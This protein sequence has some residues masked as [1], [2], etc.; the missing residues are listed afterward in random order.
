LEIV[1][2]RLAP[3]RWARAVPGL[4]RFYAQRMMAR[5]D[6]TG[7]H[8]GIYGSYEAALADIPEW[9][10]SGWDHEGTAQLWVDPVDPV[11]PSTYPV[12]FWLARVLGKNDALVNVGGSIGLTY[13]G[14]R[15]LGQMPQ[16]ATWTVVEVTKIAEQ[17]RQVAQ[18]EQARELSFVD[19]LA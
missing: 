7:L 3:G 13:Y 17:G 16:G 5:R 18:R 11:R 6:H 1:L 2:G 15:R 12:F 19:D 4:S 14:Y 9:R 10:K 8:S